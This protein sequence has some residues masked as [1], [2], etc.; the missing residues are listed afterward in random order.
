MTPISLFDDT[1]YSNQPEAEEEKDDDPVKARG[2]AESSVYLGEFFYKSIQMC[3]SL[4]THDFLFGTFCCCA[5]EVVQQINFVV[6]C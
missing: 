2:A 4:L 1:T 3:S 6:F 5:D